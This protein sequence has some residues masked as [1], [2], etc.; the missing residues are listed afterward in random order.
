[1]KPL[2]PKEIY[3]HENLQRQ[4]YQIIDRSQCDYCCI[5][6]EVIEKI[7]ELD[8]AAAKI[9]PNTVIAVVSA[10]D[11]QHGMARVWQIHV[12]KSPLTTHIFHDR[13]SADVWVKEQMSKA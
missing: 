5:R 1:M 6:P 11:L 10:N 2:S 13:Q 12:Q 3:T 4:R 9:N 7:A 8:I